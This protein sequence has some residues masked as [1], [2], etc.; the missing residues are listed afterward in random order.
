MITKPLPWQDTLWSDLI[1]RANSDNLPHALLFSGNKGVGKTALAEALTHS[2][3]CQSPSAE[4]IACGQCHGCGLLNANTH[5]DLLR[6]TPEE[7]GKAIPIDAV[8]S[9]SRFL[10]L[11]SQYGNQQVVIIN[12][13]EAMNRFAANSLLK[14]LEEPTPDTLLILITSQPSLLLPTIRSRCQQVVFNRPEANSAKSWL[15][16]QLSSREAN[17]TGQSD[18]LLALANGAPLAALALHEAG[19][20][21]IRHNLATEWVR[22]AEGKSD[23]VSCAAQWSDLGIGK[24]SQWLSSW[25]MDLI[26]LKFGADLVAMTNVDLYPQLQKLV[27][28]LDLQKLFTYLDQISETTRWARGQ[29]NAQLAMEDLMIHWSRLC[30]Q[31][32]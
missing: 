4:G 6:L 7:E 10:V 8:R 13:A 22:V 32:R 28:Q 25:V 27:G 20:L 5:P 21:E 11:K 31:V 3:L 19:E 12:P 15:N 30:R 29:L 24:A 14:T 17:S 23:P 1:R 2:L 26:R 16:E 18:T 9:A